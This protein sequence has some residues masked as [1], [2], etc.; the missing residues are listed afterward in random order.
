MK[1]R[2][3]LE[4]IVSVIWYPP[5]RHAVLSLSSNRFDFVLYYLIKIILFLIAPLVFI[6]RLGHVFYHYIKKNT[7]STPDLSTVIKLLDNKKI[8]IIG[9]ITVGG[10]GKT[11]IVAKLYEQLTQL[12]F[13]PGIVSKGYLGN[14]V[15][16]NPHQVAVNDNPKEWGDEPVLLAQ[17]LK[18]CPIIVCKN[19]VKAIQALLSSYPNVNIILTDD[20]LQDKTLANLLAQLNKKQVIKCAVI[21][22]Q[23]G[24][25]NQKLL[26]AGPLRQPKN[27]LLNIDNI[28]VHG[29][30]HKAEHAS[31]IKILLKELPG[32]QNNTSYVLSHLVSFESL[33]SSVCYTPDQFVKTHAIVRGITGIGHP[34][35]FFQSLRQ[36]GLKLETCAF[37]DH[38]DFQKSDLIFEDN[39]PIV[40][41]EKDAVKIKAFAHKLNTPVWVAKLDLMG[42]DGVIDR[43]LNHNTFFDD[44]NL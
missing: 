10:T 26:P 17:R 28:I 31:L 1:L 20:G 42:V 9:N 24:L 15:S 11:P 4:Q 8:I 12:G 44:K 39:L 41:T 38:V 18:D 25:G 22:A 2:A 35:R 13:T 21:D 16:A 27:A 5:N 43:I 3:K 6:A 30:Q 40:I 29:S 37:P 34:E 7:A 23:R 36:L 19:R 32:L 14:K 33:S